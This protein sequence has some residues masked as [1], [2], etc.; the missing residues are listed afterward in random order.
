MGEKKNRFSFSEGVK[1]LLFLICASAQ[2]EE[3]GQETKFSC[4][5]EV[6]KMSRKE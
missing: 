6:Q 3:T 2:V 5:E 4:P 1:G